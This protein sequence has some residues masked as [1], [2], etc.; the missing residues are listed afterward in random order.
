M[1]HVV[2]RREYRDGSLVGEVLVGEY[3]TNDE[4]EDA[5]E[6]DVSDFR[7]HHDNDERIDWDTVEVA[8][9][10]GDVRKFVWDVEERGG[11]NG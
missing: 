1:N 8:G 6:R 10:I 9:D 4:A 5:I 7:E 11:G 3:P 2:I